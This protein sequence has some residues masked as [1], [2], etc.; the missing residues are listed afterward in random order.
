MT[1]AYGLQFWHFVWPVDVPLIYPHPKMPPGW[2]IGLSLL[3]LIGVTALVMWR[4]GGAARTGWLWFAGMFLPLSGIVG[5]NNSVTANRYVYLP[6]IGLA[7]LI[8]FGLIGPLLELRR[9]RWILAPV[10]LL[11]AAWTSLTWRDASLWRDTVTIVT[12]ALRFAPD[13]TP[14]HHALGVALG[15]RGEFQ[16]AMKHLQRANELSPKS[17]FIL[18][19]LAILYRITQQPEHAIRR[20]Q[21]VIAL[22]PDFHEARVSLGQVYTRQGEYAQAEAAYRAVIERSP[23]FWLARLSLGNLLLGQNRLNEAVEQYQK[24]IELD[25]EDAD[26]HNN[27]G[28][29]LLKLGRAD[30][31]VKHFRRALELR[32]DHQNARHNLSRAMASQR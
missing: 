13:N 32:P 3:V 19:D 31:A 16:D 12:R 11:L 23:T 25:T 14:C 29:A 20:F 28:I 2:Q 9:N 6:M 26:T 27:L 4:G 30:E 15:R 7:V 22:K 5:I 10:V 18:N 24:V 8:G 17:A 21:Q 1:T